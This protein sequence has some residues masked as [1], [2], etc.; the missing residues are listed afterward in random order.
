MTQDQEPNWHPISALPMISQLI[1]ETLENTDEQYQTL[2]EAEDKP[3]VLDDALVDRVIR[4]Y[5]AQ[6]ED[7]AFFEE[8]LSRWKKENLTP[9]Q[10]QEIDL[11]S[12][13]LQQLREL[14]TKILSL[15]EKLKQGTI[16]SILRKSDVEL[17]I[18]VLSGKRK[19]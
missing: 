4:L 12:E 9:A 15:A 1:C 7:V 10:E 17:A 13:Q 8:Q 2:R 3:H 18:E 11:L 6:A 5:T 19:L 14:E 16:D